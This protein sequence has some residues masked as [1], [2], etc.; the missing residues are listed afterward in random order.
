[1]AIDRPQQPQVLC[2][3]PGVMGGAQRLGR[4]GMGRAVTFGPVTFV[5]IGSRVRRTPR[6]GDESG[7]ASSVGRAL[8]TVSAG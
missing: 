5:L 2:A 7:V 3:L 4:S 6:L 1:M 8:E